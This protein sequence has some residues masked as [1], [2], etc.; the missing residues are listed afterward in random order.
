MRTLFFLLAI[1]SLVGCGQPA[2]S[3]TVAA[4][5][6]S[7]EEQEIVNAGRGRAGNCAACH[8]AQGISRQPLYPSLAGRPAAELSSALY[9]FRDGERKHAIMS[10]QAR[11]LSDADIELL[12]A[13][14]AL[15]PAPAAAK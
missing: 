15:L 4:K 2:P 5:H 9:A 7:A 14:Y 12:A 10:P 1:S 8:G 13:Y 6:Y 11:G 3:Q